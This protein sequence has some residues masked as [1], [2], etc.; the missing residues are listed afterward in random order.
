MRRW[1][2]TIAI[3]ATAI[4]SIH[5]W[6]VMP[7]RCSIVERRLEQRTLQIAARAESMDTPRLA[8]DVAHT[9]LQC[10]ALRPYNVNLYMIAAANLRFAGQDTAAVDVY[11]RA[12]RYGRRPELYA[13]L[14]NALAAAGNRQEAVDYLL[15][16]NI[17]WPDAISSIEDPLVHDEVERRFREYEAQLKTRLAQ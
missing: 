4:F 6:C 3:A 2:A 17:F 11:R 1:L 9:A 8:R 12:V 5:R 13:A 15:R 16:A 10:A 7:L 14:G